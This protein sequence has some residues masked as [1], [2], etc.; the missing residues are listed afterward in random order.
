M[1]ANAELKA[2]LSNAIN[3]AFKDPRYFFEDF[4]QFPLLDWQYEMVNAVLDV[5]RKYLRLPTVVN[6]EGKPR[7]TIRSCH[8]TG[9]TQGIAALAHIYNFINYETK[10]AATAP[11]RDQ[12]TRRIMPRYRKTMQ[13]A[14][15]IYQDLIT[16][17]GNET[18]INKNKDWGIALETASDPDNLAGYHDEPQLFLI[19]E[20]SSRRLDPMFPVIEG[21]LSTPGSCCVEIGNPTRVDGEFYKHHNKKELADLYYRM[22]I[23]YRD[24]GDYISPQWVKSMAIK[25]GIDSPIYKIRVLGE[26]ANFEDSILIPLEFIEEAYDSDLKPD[27]SHPR[28]RVSVDVAD[29]GADKTVITVGKRYQSYDH[30]LYQKAFSFEPSV[31]VLKSAETAINIFEGFEGNKKYD[32]FVVDANGV[33]AGTAGKLISAGYNVVRHVGGESS[34]NPDRWRNRRTQNHFAMEDRFTNLA[35]KID[36]ENIDDIEEFEAHILAVKRAN[37]DD[38]K[39]DEIQSAK[40]VKKD[41]GESPDRSASL[42]MFFHGSS[43][44]QGI[45][46]TDTEESD[47]ILIGGSVSHNDW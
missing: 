15:E 22:H 46:Q 7:V 11:K 28:L 36:S 9:K 24:A 13:N 26:F 2:V 16:I 25:Y 5:Q 1:T 42:S 19:D 30:I 18:L 17:L 27:G 3:N 37:D 34:D 43:S 41:L 40:D 47:F 4:L 10:I 38:D 6:H 12:L 32:D 8:G 39:R 14:P 33:G 44:S 35:I 21:A 45:E 29:G 20:A 23:D 31:A